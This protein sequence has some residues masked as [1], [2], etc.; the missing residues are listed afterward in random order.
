MTAIKK[1]NKSKRQKQR[2]HFSVMMQDEEVYKEFRNYVKRKHGKLHTVLAQEVEQ[3]LKDVMY[4][5]VIE[6]LEDSGVI[7]NSNKSSGIIITE[8]DKHRGYG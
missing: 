8:R 4:K 7:V 3:A 5:D 6:K 2:K 1:S